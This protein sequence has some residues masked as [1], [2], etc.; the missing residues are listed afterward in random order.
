MCRLS[1]SCK[2]VGQEEVPFG[3]DTCVVYYAGGPRPPQEEEIWGLEAAVDNDAAAC[4]QMS[5]S[6]VAATVIGIMC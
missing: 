1:Q 2:A 4:Q 5:L 6:V 3:R